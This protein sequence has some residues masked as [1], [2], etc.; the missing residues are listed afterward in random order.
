MC[1]ER[2]QVIGNWE[3]SGLSIPE[4]FFEY[5]SAYLEASLAITEEIK[6]RS[7][8]KTWPNASVAM[9]LAVHSVELFLKGAILFQEPK[10]K[11]HSHRLA[12]LKGIYDGIYPEKEYM[13][14]LPFRTEYLGI[15]EEEAAIIA[16][17]EPVPSIQ[18]RYPVDLKGG[19]WGDA[20]GFYPEGF[21]VVLED[22]KAIYERINK[23][24]QST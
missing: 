8:M 7:A 24:L 11:L 9:M 20:S 12:A 21:M 19:E 18:Y 15:S 23:L 16:K 14:E 3:I 6:C 2:I 22:L 17:K 5:A 13:W 10:K 1:S 4:K